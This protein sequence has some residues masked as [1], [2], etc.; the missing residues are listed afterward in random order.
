MK[1]QAV[2]GNLVLAEV[3][4]DGCGTGK[5]EKELLKSVHWESLYCTFLTLLEAAFFCC[6]KIRE[7]YHMLIF[8]CLIKLLIVDVLSQQLL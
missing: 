7:G 1:I 4:A 5:K 3:F 6:Y 8:L 2:V